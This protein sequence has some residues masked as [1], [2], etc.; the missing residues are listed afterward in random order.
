VAAR[1]SDA[2]GEPVRG[3]RV[4]VEAFHSARAGR[5]F[6]ATLSA[7]PG[8]GYSASL[9]L[10]RVGLWELRVRVERGEQVFTQIINQD[11]ARMP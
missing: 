2:Q 7:E 9:P 8:G 10:D 11:L 5:L 1:V 4:A 6:T 3:A